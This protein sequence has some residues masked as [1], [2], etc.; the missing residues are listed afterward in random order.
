MKAQRTAKLSESLA[1]LLPE[2]S[3]KLIPTA[4]KAELL[5]SADQ[6]PLTSLCG[7]EYR[8]AD[9]PSTQVDLQQVFFASRDEQKLLKN[10]I[11]ES[12]LRPDRQTEQWSVISRVSQAWSEQNLVGIDEIWL[13]H[14]QPS[15]PLAEP[16]IFAALEPSLSKKNNQQLALNC[17]QL[18]APNR[19]TL[20]T[21]LVAL[22]DALPTTAYLALIGWMGQRPEAPLRLIISGVQPAEIA[23]LLRTINCSD[24]AAQIYATAD[25]LLDHVDRVR[26]CL[27]LDESGI[28]KRIGLE[29]LFT[30]KHVPNVLWHR[31][32]KDLTF[33]EASHPKA[34]NPL[35]NWPGLLVPS[36]A[37]PWPAE[38]LRQSLLVEAEKFTSI[39]KRIGHIKVDIHADGTKKAKAYFGY[40]HQ[41]AMSGANKTPPIKKAPEKQLSHRERVRRYYNRMNESILDSVGHT[42]QSGLINHDLAATHQLIVDACQI[43]PSDHIVD[44]GCGCGGPAIELSKLVPGIRIDGCTISENQ[45]TA[46]KKLI[47][48]AALDDKIHISVSDYHALPYKKNLFS[49]A[50]FLET[51]GYS[52]NPALLLSETK[53]VLKP[54]GRIAIKDFF[55]TDTPPAEAGNNY[56]QYSP[57][58]LYHIFY[59]APVLEMLETAGFTN[60]NSHSLDNMT[61]DDFNAAMCNEDGE[62]NNF[63]K[64]HGFYKPDNKKRPMLITATLRP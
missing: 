36:D 38:W 44:M 41:W 56:S 53:R 34:I 42:Y 19:P 40:E 33:L 54:G 37:Q 43:Q 1:L 7:F 9:T 21:K 52:D 57:I 15:G 63:G 32:L 61:Y 47:Y 62:M 23:A 48:Q 26:L 18:F 24:N 17:L 22:L 60:I 13:E 25:R 16:G 29:A 50:T 64:Q 11:R 12:N 4:T 31:V 51:F 6:L 39:D 49:V 10:W 5:R 59:L 14:D 20:A 3:E 30:D 8:L 35:L 45:A 27:A 58:Y 55:T 28:D 2:V 46:A